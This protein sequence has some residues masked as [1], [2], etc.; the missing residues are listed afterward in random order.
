MTGPS[1]PYSLWNSAMV[2]SPDGRGVILFGG[3]TSSDENTDEK[4]IL[5]LRAGGDSWNI[6]D[7]TL[8]N[9]RNYHVVIPLI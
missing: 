9:A 5:E 6:L 7:I 1:L 3:D 2:Q 8:Q 4:R